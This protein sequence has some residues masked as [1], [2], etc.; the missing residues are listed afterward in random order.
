MSQV[1]DVVT[2]TKKTGEG[3][4]STLTALKTSP[5]VLLS[6]PV[7]LT[8]RGVKLTHAPPNAAFITTSFVADVESV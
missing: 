7:R 3:A 8:Y 4:C 6:N 5:G 1:G 2:V